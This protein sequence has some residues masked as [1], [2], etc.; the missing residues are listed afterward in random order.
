MNFKYAFRPHKPVM[1]AR[2]ALTFLKILALKQKPLRY[3]DFNITD[4][5]NLTCRHCFATAFTRSDR[6]KMEIED[7]HR[8]MKQA[9]ELGAVN[10]SFQGGEPLLFPRLEDLIR[11][12]MPYK[13]VISVTTNGTLLTPERARALRKL[14]VDIFTIS[15]DSLHAED[16]DAIRNKR[17]TF[18]KTMRGIEA[19]IANG[20]NVTVGTVLSHQ[21]IRTEGIENLFD[22]ACR[23]KLTLCLSLAVPVGEWAGNSDVVLTE[24]DLTYLAA[25]KKK[26]PYVRTDFEANYLVW[27]CGAI[28]EILYI[29]PYGDVLPC[30]YIHVSFGNIFEKSL[31][32]IRTNAMQ[33]K[34]FADYWQKCLCATDKDFIGE[35]LEKI[36]KHEALPVG[37]EDVFDKEPPRT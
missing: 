22:W 29:T 37:Y 19:A 23:K 31:E 16:H 9:N 3:V 2:L 14:G 26:Y 28:K 33:N 15:L 20:C 18:E 32:E 13:N 5:C 6:R 10:F 1:M 36:N 24:D 17:G 8:V 11:A 34:Y 35:F 4:K 27:G 12:A 25:L 21:N 7:Y 30:P